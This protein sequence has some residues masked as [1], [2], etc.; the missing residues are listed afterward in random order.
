MYKF[1]AFRLTR[2][3]PALFRNEQA[4]ECD[5]RVLQLLLMLIDHRDGV[6]SREQLIDKLWQGRVVSDASLSQLIHR[7]RQLLEDDG[8][9]PQYIQTVH[10]RGFRWLGPVE[11]QKPNENQTATA[12]AKGK[13]LYRTAALW[14]GSLL[15]LVLVVLLVL[16]LA[17]QWPGETP[18]PLAEKAGENRVA[19]LPFEYTA[20]DMQYS[21]VSLGLM[22]M[23]AEMLESSPE[24]QLVPGRKVVSWLEAH[25]EAA[26]DPETLFQNL[27]PELGC[28]RLLVTQVGGNPIPD[29]LEAYWLSETGRSPTI[30]LQ[31]TELTQLARQLAIRLIQPYRQGPLASGSDLH[32]ASYS[33]SPQANQAYALALQAIQQDQRKLAAQYLRIAVGQ[34]PDFSMALAHLAKME[35]RLGQLELADEHVQQ[36]LQQEGA[37]WQARYL[38]LVTLSNIQYSRGE[39]EQS[40]QTT[41]AMLA[42]THWPMNTEQRAMLSMNMGTSLQR[43][44]RLDEARQWLQRSE[45]LAGESRQTKLQTSA[46]F[47]LG[48]LALTRN[49]FEEALQWYQKAEKAFIQQGNEQ[50]ALL[51][52]FQIATI[53][54]SL[55][56]YNE[57]I[58]LFAQLEKDSQRLDDREGALLARIE[59]LDAENRYKPDPDTLIRVLPGIIR[60]ADDWQLAY[61][62]HMARYLLAYAWWQKGKAESGLQWLNIDSELSRNDYNTQMVYALLQWQA[63][64]LDLALKHARKARVLAADGWTDGYNQWLMAMEQAEEQALDYAQATARLS[65]PLSTQ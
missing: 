41:E 48:S 26:K 54:K 11:E 12:P 62:S 39:L 32:M 38:A 59:R 5:P 50:N 21:W 8:K 23:V 30:Q 18:S 46:W 57:A 27:C 43:L 16:A 58:A 56:H 10:G 55:R 4:V 47:N 33:A 34:A 64:R 2:N 14:A 1:G 53:Y 63:G 37:P 13:S 65:A 28:Q 45:A 3:P 42:N 15:L 24:L 44:N 22:E 51:A 36:V 40:L 29:R 35:E 60:Q 31:G 25:P 19:L 52:R 9:S 17:P 7:A 20:N 49:H 61:P 6:L